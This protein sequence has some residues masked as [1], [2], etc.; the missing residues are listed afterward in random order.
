MRFNFEASNGLTTPEEL[1]YESNLKA[2]IEF[3]SIEI[4]VELTVAFK[5]SHLLQPFIPGSS[6]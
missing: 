4:S 3:W 5:N 2:I 6:L 1:S